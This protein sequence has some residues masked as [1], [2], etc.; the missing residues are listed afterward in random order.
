MNCIVC[1]RFMPKATLVAK[2]GKTT[3]VQICPLCVSLLFSP[4]NNLG[5]VI[6]LN[7]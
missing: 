3:I 4:Q 7:L 1:A 6:K 2:D 5:H